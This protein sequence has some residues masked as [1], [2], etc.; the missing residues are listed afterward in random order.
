MF[1]LSLGPIRLSF[2]M[3]WARLL[4]YV[5]GTLNQELLLRNE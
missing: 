2:R 4:V 3:L 5:T 1:G